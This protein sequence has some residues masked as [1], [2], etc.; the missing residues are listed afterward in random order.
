MKI[1]TLVVSTILLSSNF[2]SA[3]TMIDIAGAVQGTGEFA[4]YGSLGSQN[5]IP[6]SSVTDGDF[7]LTTK[8]PQG[9]YNNGT[10]HGINWS[11]SYPGGSGMTYSTGQE[12]NFRAGFAGEESSAID[13]G[14]VD[15]VLETAG[16][17]PFNWSAVSVQLWRN[18][19]GAATHY[20]FAYDADADGYGTGDLLGT[21]TNVSSSGVTGTT[22]NELATIS[23]NAADIATSISSSDTIRLF[24][25]N[26]SSEGGNTH[27]VNVSAEYT[28]VPEPG[29][30][31]LTLLA[32]AAG[33]LMMRRRR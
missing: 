28:V 12:I 13:G 31:A 24:F 15:I 6:D 17:T 25:W 29:T 14:Y 20:R 33:I 27:I 4:D 18:G 8:F 22:P 7:T 19:T 3:A 26:A 30:L 32:G 16:A 5:L 9:A 2:A 21:A 23:Y 11:G 1:F 10:N